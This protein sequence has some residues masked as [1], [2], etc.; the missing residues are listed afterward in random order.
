MERCNPVVLDQWQRLEPYVGLNRPVVLAYSGGADSSV[1]LA[2]LV[3]AGQAKTLIAATYKSLL[4]H[5]GELEQAMALTEKL[6]VE[7]LI[8]EEDPMADEEFS[9]NPEERCYICKK[10]RLEGLAALARE[11]GALVLDGTNF[12]DT[13]VHRPGLKALEE[14]GVI[15]PLAQAGLTKEQVGEL[16]QW[17]GV[18]A[19]LK[20][21]SACLATRVPY[22]FPLTTNLL[23]DIRRAEERLAA[24][25]GLELGSFRVRVHGSLVRLETNP[26]LWTRIMKPDLL[27]LVIREMKGLGFAHVALDLEGYISGSMDRKGKKQNR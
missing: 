20:P 9:A 2:A 19:W 5:S 21:A 11:R 1:L 14:A 18:E 10:R 25:L 7:H 27:S 6:G 22:G 24:L 26:A 15:A 8:M 3:R 17:L 12:S 13:K 23:T 4:H 16:G